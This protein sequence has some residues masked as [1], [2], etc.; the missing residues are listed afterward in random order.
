VGGVAVAVAVVVLVLLVAGALAKENE[1][2]K[3][4]TRQV[5]FLLF[6]SLPF[7]SLTSA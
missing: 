2:S 5:S 3:V 1:S 4:E 7:S 6:S